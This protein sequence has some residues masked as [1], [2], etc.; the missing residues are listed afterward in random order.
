MGR[1]YSES[2]GINKYLDSVERDF[3]KQYGI[4]PDGADI[5]ISQ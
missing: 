1:R 4:T 3:F 2:P 5:E